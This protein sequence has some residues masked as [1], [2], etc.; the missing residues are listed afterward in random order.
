MLATLPKNQKEI[1][2]DDIV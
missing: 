2:R 1:L